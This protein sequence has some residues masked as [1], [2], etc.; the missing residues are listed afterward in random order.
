M[1]TVV[2]V[3]I[4]D[5]F[6]QAGLRRMQARLDR[7][8]ELL[9]SE[10][11]HEVGPL[12]TTPEPE[13]KPEFEESEGLRVDLAFV[14]EVFERGG[15]GWQFL[16]TCYRMSAANTAFTLKE[17]AQHMDCEHKRVLAFSRNIGRSAK[18]QTQHLDVLKATQ[19]VGRYILNGTIRAAV[20][21]VLNEQPKP[22]EDE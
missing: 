14:R 10:V 22:A 6:N 19:H 3:T 13:D 16:E 8:K 17:V 4:E 5:E 7:Y 11:D 12:L 9:K 20:R 2:R 1:S 15:N 18:K 21:I